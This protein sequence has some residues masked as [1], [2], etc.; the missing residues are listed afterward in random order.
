LPQ[1]AGACVEDTHRVLGAI[2]REDMSKVGP[3]AALW[4]PRRGRQL[5][6]RLPGAR[7]DHAHT[8]AVSLIKMVSVRIDADLVRRTGS[9]SGTLPATRGAA[10]TRSTSEQTAVRIE[11]QGCWMVND[12][13]KAPVDTP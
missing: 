11:V 12:G 2:A 3:G 5:E 7:V 10:L 13:I 1:F 9:G 6:D 8:L 4:T